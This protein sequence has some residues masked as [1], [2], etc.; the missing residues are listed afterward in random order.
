M[1]LLCEG[2]HSRV[3]RG[4]WSKEKVKEARRTPW[5]VQAGRCHD[6]FDVGDSEFIVWAGANRIVNI[7]TILKIDGIP[8]LTIE[9]PE[10]PGGPYRLSGDFYSSDDRRLFRI[11]RN[12]WFG[13]IHNWDI[14][15]TGGQITIRTASNRIALQVT[16]DP[17]KGIIIEKMNMIH[18]KTRFSVED[19]E[20]RVGAYDG[21]TVIV[22]GREIVAKSNGCLAFSAVSE[23]KHQGHPLGGGSLAIGKALQIGGGIGSFSIGSFA[24]P[25]DL[26]AGTK[27]E[28]LSKHWGTI[29]IRPAER[30]KLGR[31]DPCL[32]GSGRKYKKCCALNL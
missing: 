22:L 1:A 24:K 16:C 10:V 2:C 28:Y 30:E 6:A 4:F 9:R 32:C 19:Y 27:G 11:V 21:S 29:R 18:R 15:C 12:E 13:E 23:G 7:E 14:E 17:P 25:S 3:T 5:C 20:L 26:P 31:N 8:I